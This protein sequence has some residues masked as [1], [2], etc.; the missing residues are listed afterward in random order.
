VSY[1]RNIISLKSLGLLHHF[2]QLGS[3]VKTDL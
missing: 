2:L 1:Y 3:A